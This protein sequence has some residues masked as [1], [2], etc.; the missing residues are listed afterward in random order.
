MAS[1]ILT[2]VRLRAT[3]GAT[4]IDR[5]KQCAALTMVG[6][7]CVAGSCI[8]PHTTPEP[9]PLGPLTEANKGIMWIYNP[10][11]TLDVI[12][13]VP[14]LSGAVTALVAAPTAGGTGYAV[15]NI[16]HIVA[17]GLGAIV[18]V[19]AAAAGVVT[20]VSLVF[21]GA[22]YQTGAGKTTELITG[23]GDDG[24]TV[25]ITTVRAA[26]GLAELLRVKAGEAHLFRCGAASLPLYWMVAT[27]GVAV[28]VERIIV[29]A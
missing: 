12:I 8:V 23:A 11:A 25:E 6:T 19:D 16:V 7:D 17:P 27:G 28:S 24:L 26:L 1:E 22:T 3:K 15:G 20:A 18:R 13:G 9:I 21:G 5:V 14:S 29:Q 2:E 4:N 10:H